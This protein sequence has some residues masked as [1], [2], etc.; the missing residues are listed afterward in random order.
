MKFKNRYILL[1]TPV[2]MLLA[3]ACASTPTPWPTPPPRPTSTPTPEPELP[4]PTATLTP[5]TV[6]APISTPSPTPTTT[7]APCES[8][9]AKNYF[10]SVSEEVD[11]ISESTDLLGDQFVELTNDPTLLSYDYWRLSVAT[12]LAFMMAG[13]DALLELEAPPSLS[14][15]HAV[16]RQIANETNKAAKL[17]AEGLDELSPSKIQSANQHILNATGYLQEAD[18]IQTRLCGK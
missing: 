8:P 6:L 16:I 13:A 17:Y 10:G 18:R 12:S 14:E 15:L 1:A 7:P 9:S 5:T 11:S 2:I 3:L 4:R